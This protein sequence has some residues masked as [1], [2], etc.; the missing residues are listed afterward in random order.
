[1]LDAMSKATATTASGTIQCMRSQRSEARTGLATHSAQLTTANL[2][3][4]MMQRS[5]PWI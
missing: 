5:D 2:I 1:M 4:W 3:T